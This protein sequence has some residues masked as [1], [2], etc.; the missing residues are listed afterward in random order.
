VKDGSFDPLGLVER[1]DVEAPGAEKAHSLRER[2]FVPTELKLLFGL[3]GLEVTD[4]WGGTAGNWGKRPIDLDE[5]E[6]MVTGRKA[7]G[8]VLP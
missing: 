4:I 1:S 5:I 8:P 3:A 6:I 7:T 2:G